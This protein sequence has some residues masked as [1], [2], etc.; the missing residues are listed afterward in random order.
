MIS[1]IKAGAFDEVETV[2]PNRKAIMVY[3]ISQVCEPKKKLNLQNFNGLLK[4][5]LVP[6]NLE[7]QIRVYNFTK[8]LK[9]YRKTKDYFHLDDTCISFL[10]RFFP[11]VLDMTEINENGSFFLK[12]SN[13]DKIYQSQM[14]NVRNWLKENQ[15]EV[16]DKYNEILFKEMWNDKAK[17]TES[18]W[19]MEA[20]TFYHGDHELKNVN[21]NKYNLADFNKLTSNEIDYFIKRKGVQIPI[22]KLYRIAG[23]VIAKDDNRHTIYL[24]TT[25]GVVPVKFTKDYYAM[26]KRQISQIQ[27][28]GTKK[29]V[30]KSWFKR[31]TMLMIT[32]FKREDQF[33]GKTYSS[34]NTHQLYKITDIIGEDIKLQHERFSANGTLEE[35]YEE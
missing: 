24:L 19:E 4:Y 27:E 18:H 28:D 25:T 30:E 11:E 9:G 14:D 17:G 23:T 1:L 31:G 26:F 5:N 7:L 35:D 16:L 20:L 2:L 29:V 34:T 8:Y 22:Y 15:K 13:W 12:Q 6:Q 21:A 32:G 10:E 3:Y 33:I